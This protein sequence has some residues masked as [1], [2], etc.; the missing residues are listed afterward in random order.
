[1]E[2]LGKYSACQLE[3]GLKD[4]GLWDLSI[5]IADL[6]LNL[7][8]F[9]TVSSPHTH[10]FLEFLKPDPLRFSPCRK[11]AF[12]LLLESETS[13]CSALWDQRRLVGSYTI[14]LIL[15]V[16]HILYPSPSQSSVATIPESFWGSEAY[17]GLFSIKL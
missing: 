6:S 13:N 8:I 10:L 14:T 3:K 7:L 9:S 5:Q 12:S 16:F 11:W 2:V 4:G 15:L 1:M 17:S